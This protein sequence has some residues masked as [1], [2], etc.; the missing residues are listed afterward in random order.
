MLRIGMTG[1]STVLV[2][3]PLTRLRHEVTLA[4]TG[5]GTLV[6]DSLEWTSPCGPLGRVADSLV[7]RRLVLRVLAN[8]A[9]GLRDRA[10]ELAAAPVVVGAAIVREGRLLVQQRAYPAE[11]AGRWEL[12]G[13]RVEPGETD[14]EALVR[15]CREELGV[16]VVPGD[17]VGPD[18]PLPN[19]KVL[20]LLAARLADPAAEPRPY[21]HQ[22]LS[23]SAAADLVDMDWLP[24]DRV[25]VPDLRRLL[26]AS[27]PAGA[28]AHS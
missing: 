7:G 8:R 19:G 18:I 24:A 10:E 21:D 14:A 25:V 5:A 11:C 22:A 26:A 15:E 20:R 1:M 4:E 16:E 27:G 6:T 3:G 28:V 2:A 13:G 9:R 23:W 12:P 17:Q